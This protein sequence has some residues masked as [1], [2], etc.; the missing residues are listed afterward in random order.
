MVSVFKQGVPGVLWSYPAMF[1]CYFILQRRVAMVLGVVLTMGVTVASAWT[2]EPSLAVRVFGSLAFVMTMINVVLNVVGD[3][4]QALVAQTITDPLTGAFN[5]RHMDQQLGVCVASAE[6]APPVES[7]LV[8]D[9]DHFKRI[10][11]THGHDVGDE[12][13][14]KVVTAVASRKRRSDLLFRMGGEEFLLLLPGAPLDQA[15]KIAEEL[16]Q[17]LAHAELLPGEPVTVSIGVSA[18]RRG[19]TADAWI[20]SADTALYR[21]KRSGRN[22]VVLAEVDGESATQPG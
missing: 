8:I 12:V 1:I 10:N 20:K 7:L 16:R 13:L 4:Q 14:R 6:A 3:L 11:D 18:L 19:Q 9:I 15:Q 5:R 2:L 17:R 22:R 21:A